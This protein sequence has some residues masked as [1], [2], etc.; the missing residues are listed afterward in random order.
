M[1]AQ[2]KLGYG[3]GYEMKRS[4][5]SSDM[6]VMFFLLPQRVFK[7]PERRQLFSRL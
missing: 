1:A 3:S 2:A 4:I 5:S 7:S 6:L